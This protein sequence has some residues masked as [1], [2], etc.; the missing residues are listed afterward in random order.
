MCT[1]EFRCPQKLKA[2]AHTWELN[3]C[4]V[5]KKSVFLTSKPPLQPIKKKTFINFLLE[6]KIHKFWMLTH[7]EVPATWESGSRRITW[8]SKVKGQP[9]QHRPLLKQTDK[10]INTVKWDTGKLGEDISI[11]FEN[12]RHSRWLHENMF[13]HKENA[14]SAELLKSIGKQFQNWERDWPQI[15]KNTSRG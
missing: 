8:T 14:V 7:P 15:Y 4:P 5:K 11:M 13:I 6:N 1:H 12:I 10:S 3:S 9:G 2:L